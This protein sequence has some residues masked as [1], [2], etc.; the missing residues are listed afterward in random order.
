MIEELKKVE[1]LFKNN[2]NSKSSI[3]LSDLLMSGSNTHKELVKL[4]EDKLK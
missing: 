3:G 4:L 2:V 1:K